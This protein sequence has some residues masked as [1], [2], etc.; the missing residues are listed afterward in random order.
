MKITPNYRQHTCDIY[1]VFIIPSEQ[2]ITFSFFALSSSFLVS[3]TLSKPFHFSRSKRPS[4]S[5]YRNPPA[6]KLE[7]SKHAK[8]GRIAV[9]SSARTWIVIGISVAGVLIL[10]EA[11]RRHHRRRGLP[12]D[13][14]DFGAFIE[15]FELA[16]YP[17]PPLPAARLSLSGLSFAVSDK[18]VDFSHLFLVIC[19][20]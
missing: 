7:L 1:S 19:L 4:F 3:K 12:R 8:L 16:P 10:A 2:Y 5:L 17:Q 20:V 9:P 13:S 14:K 6:S 15:R 18:W 11:A